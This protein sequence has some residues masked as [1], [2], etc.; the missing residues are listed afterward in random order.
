MCIRFKSTWPQKS[1]RYTVYARDNV[2]SRL[3]TVDISEYLRKFPSYNSLLV[4]I[5]DIFEMPV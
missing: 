1:A 5:H 2:N 3:L 4:I